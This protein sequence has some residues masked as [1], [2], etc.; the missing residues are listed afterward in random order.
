MK[1]FMTQSMESEGVAIMERVARVVAPPHLRPISR[2]EFLS[3]I[4]D[5]DGAVMVWHTEMMDRDAF[6]HAPNLKVVARRGVG[7]DNIDIEEATRR[8]V[9]VTVCP[10]NIPTIADTAF[11]LIMCAARRFPQA[12]QFVRSGQWTEGGSWVAFKF[13]G[14]NIHH[15]TLGLVGLGRIGQEVA[16]RAKGF[17]MKILYYD[18][19]RRPEVEADMGVIFSPMDELLATSDFVSLNCAL[20]EATYHLINER[21][22]A[23]MKP[24]AILVNTSRGPTVDLDA[25][26]RALKAGRLG[27]AGLDVF[28]PEPV[29]VD[30]PILTLENVVF[31]PHLGT[32]TMRTRV[33]IAK[34]VANCVVSVLSGEEPEFLLNKEVRQVR[35]LKPHGSVVNA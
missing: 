30:H 10:L 4:A 5:A 27:G 7:Y 14:E 2:E 12:D 22:L 19:I 16:K 3:G 1:V 13:M 21:T 9:Y 35:P 31:T 28:D 29:P 23:M 18:T 32:S 24:T 33:E 11:G 8:G 15:A 17:D 25:L 20:N 34:A 6:E 26:Y